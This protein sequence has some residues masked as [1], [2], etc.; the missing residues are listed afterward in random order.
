MTLS[1]CTCTIGEV[2]IETDWGNFM[3]S[4]SLHMCALEWVYPTSLNGGLARSAGECGYTC[5]SLVRTSGDDGG[6]RGCTSHFAF[7][8]L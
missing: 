2:F 5:F 8:F 4:L 1:T 7:W 3:D 6:K